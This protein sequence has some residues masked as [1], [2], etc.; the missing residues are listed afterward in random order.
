MIKVILRD[1]KHNV[2]AFSTIAAVR[3]TPRDIFLAAKVDDSIAAAARSNEN[4]YFIQKHDPILGPDSANPKDYT[5][6]PSFAAFPVARLLQFA[7]AVWL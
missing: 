2:A 7:L 1:D 5:H 3:P 6:P 4:L